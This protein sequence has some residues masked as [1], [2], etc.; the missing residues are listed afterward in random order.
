[1]LELPALEKLTCD[2][3]NMFLCYGTSIYTVL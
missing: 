1:M 3:K 2:T